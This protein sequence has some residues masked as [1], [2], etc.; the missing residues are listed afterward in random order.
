MEVME[1][2]NKIRDGLIW[3]DISFRI[4][5]NSKEVEDISFIKRIS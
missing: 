2:G 4:D 5:K 1:V 3:A